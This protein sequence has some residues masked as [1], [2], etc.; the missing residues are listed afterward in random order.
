MENNELIAEFMGGRK[1]IVTEKKEGGYSEGTVLWWDLFDESGCTTY[2]DFDSSWD[3]LMPVVEK[4]WK[5][6]KMITINFFSKPSI[7]STR[8]YSWGLGDDIHEREQESDSIIEAVYKAVVE[9]IKWHNEENQ[10]TRRRS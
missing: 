6:D 8:I 7:V 1:Q 4:I 10:N 2:L 3:W 5:M 9:F